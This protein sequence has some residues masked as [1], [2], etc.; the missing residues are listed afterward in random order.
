M[1]KGSST[2]QPH[3]IYTAISCHFLDIINAPFEKEPPCNIVFTHL[4]VKYTDAIAYIPCSIPK[5][6]IP[7]NIITLSNTNIHCDTEIFGIIL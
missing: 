5:T 4:L 3:A 1:K 6:T 7:S 2:T